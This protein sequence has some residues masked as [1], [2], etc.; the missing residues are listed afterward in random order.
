MDKESNYVHV[1]TPECFCPKCGKHLVSGRSEDTSCGY[2]MYIEC[3]T[4][5]FE[6]IS[7]TLTYCGGSIIT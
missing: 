6:K 4:K 2:I 3:P 1:C 7:G 5:H